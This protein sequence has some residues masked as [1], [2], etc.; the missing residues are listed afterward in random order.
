MKSY[1]SIPRVM[2]A[3][4]FGERCHVFVKYDGSN[5]R[6]EWSKKKGWYKHGT[7][8]RLFGPD[9][10]PY[11]QAIELF[12]PIGEQV[13]R[14]VR[15]LYQNPEEIIAFT[16]FFGPSS[17]AG[18]HDLNEPKELKLID[19]SV[20]KKGFIPPK[21]FVEHF[22][23][24]WAATCLSTSAFLDHDLID[25]V[26]G[27][28]LAEDGVVEGVVCKG[29]GKKGIWSAKIKTQAYLDRLKEKFGRDWEKFV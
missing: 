9:E 22:S 23:Q 28:K 4:K 21:I 18:S 27:G 1:P 19:V 26:R 29:F 15:E 17:F 6:W 3:G 20:Y 2:D 25:S 12:K 16:E 5:L 14:I 24:P 7:R 8:H 11:N 10:A 13:E